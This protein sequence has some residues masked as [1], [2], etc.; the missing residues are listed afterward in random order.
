MISSVLSTSS[1]GI[2]ICEWETMSPSEYRLSSFG[3]KTCT[4]WRAIAARLRSRISSSDLPEN[5]GPAITSIH[6]APGRIGFTFDVPP[7]AED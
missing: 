3:L 5:M 7:E 4:R 6:P 1:H 2:R